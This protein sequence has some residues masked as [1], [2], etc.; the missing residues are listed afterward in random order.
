MTRPGGQGEPGP[1]RSRWFA[2][3]RGDLVR[4]SEALAR[5]D[6]LTR[7][8]RLAIARLAAYELVELG[9]EQAAAEA[10]LRAL[11]ERPAGAAAPDRAADAD[12]AALTARCEEVRRAC[13]QNLALLAH[14]RRSVSLLLGVDEDRAGYD[15]R[16]RRLTGSS[17]LTRIRAL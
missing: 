3:S 14:A 8:Q 17:S 4:A 9:R 6:D 13:R 2:L 16:A 12:L 7:R 1:G 11:V 15:R 5:L 10:E